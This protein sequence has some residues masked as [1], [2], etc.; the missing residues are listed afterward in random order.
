METAKAQADEIINKAQNSAKRQ[1]EAIVTKA[2]DTADSIVRQAENQA[3]LEIKKAEDGI[4]KE[5]V[6]VSSLLANKLLEREIN[7]E[8]HRSLIDSF[9]EKIGDEE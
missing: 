2:K 7:A 9:I 1:G 5:I 3:Q 8:D 6:E 4:K